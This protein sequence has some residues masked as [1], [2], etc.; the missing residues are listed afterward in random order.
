[1]I[2]S[3]ALS[4]L[5][6]TT[7]AAFAIYGKYKKQKLIHYAFKPLTMLLIISL[8]WERSVSSPSPY[9]YLVLS[10]LCISLLG[11]IF[12][13][14]PSDKFK[15]G[16][17]AFFIAH[18]LY[19]F[20]FSRDIRVV[21]FSSLGPIAA[22]GVI[23][24]LIL[25]AKIRGLRIFVLIYIIGISAMAWLAVNRYFFFADQQSLLVM[26]GGLLFLIS[27]A[28]NAVNRFRKAFWLAQILILGTYYAAQLAFA[29]SL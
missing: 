18:L 25:W 12:L 24:F 14:L 2:L 26:V 28:V 9:G 4:V 20:A 3:L 23:V 29:L 22:F 1:M 16:L 17:L 27:D 6:I 5:V 21:S 7:S 15:P 8:A 13:M 11:D 19:I 10:G